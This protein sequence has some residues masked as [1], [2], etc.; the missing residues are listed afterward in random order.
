MRLKL[1]M[2]IAL[3]LILISTAD[4]ADGN[5]LR[6]PGAYCYDDGRIEILGQNRNVDPIYLG[7]TVVTGEHQELGK[8]TING[9]WDKSEI[10][11]ISAISEK[12]TFTSSPGH[13]NLSGKYL[14][15]VEYEGCRHPPCVQG[16]TVYQCPGFLYSCEMSDLQI[17]KAFQRGESVWINFQGVN[18][19]QYDKQNL[20]EVLLISKFGNGPT[21]D[22]KIIDA[23]MQLKY[24]GDDAY[25]LIIPLDA[26]EE[27][28]KVMIAVKEC[29]EKDK[30]NYAEYV[31]KDPVRRK[32]PVPTFNPVVEEPDVEEEPEN[33]DSEEYA[34]PIVNTMED[35]MEQSGGL[36]M[37]TIILIIVGWLVALA[38]VIVLLILQYRK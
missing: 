24:R 16:Y 9:S 21:F 8:F 1:F 36:T 14:I 18:K 29:V 27:I 15:N 11:S 20:E 22:K 28:Y 30:M 17:T 6:I 10:S 32:E 35:D 12:A 7:N 5:V 4:A 31:I 38:A 2:Y 34:K 37:N 13:L 33:N 19:N 23:T 3:F 26:G 25:T